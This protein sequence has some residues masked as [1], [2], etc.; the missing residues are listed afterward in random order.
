MNPLV[1]LIITIIAAIVAFRIDT[2]LGIGFIVVAIIYIYFSNRANLIVGKANAAYSMG[3]KDGAIDYYKKAVS[4]A[5]KNPTLRAGYALMLLRCE[6]PDE[7]LSQINSLLSTMN[8]P[9]NI[10]LQAKQIRA[11]INHRLGNYGDAYEEGMDVFESGH[12]TSAMRGLLGL[13]MLSSEKDDNKT[14]KF[15]ED[16]FDYDAD[17]RD[18]L[19]NYLLILIK[20]KNYD[21]AKEISNILLENTT[22]FPECYYHSAQLYMALGDKNKAK[23]LLEKTDNCK[24]TYMTTVTKDEIDTLKAQL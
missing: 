15:C 19:D 10:K 2:Y 3:D 9:Q 5:K 22:D 23:E 20:T 12:T 21:K 14:L 13:L 8:L 4:S 11:L 6:Q 18:I 7:A 16:C 1:S 17:N 24:F